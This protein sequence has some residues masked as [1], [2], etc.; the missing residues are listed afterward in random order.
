MDTVTLYGIDLC[1]DDRLELDGT[2]DGVELNDD[3]SIT[4]TMSG[5]MVS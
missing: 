5:R 2:I 4:I 3:G 1:P